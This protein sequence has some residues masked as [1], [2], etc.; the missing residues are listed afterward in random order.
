MKRERIMGFV[1]AYG[2]GSMVLVRPGRP[3]TARAIR[4]R[5]QGRNPQGKLTVM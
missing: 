3:S 4:L 1:R 5:R 2:G